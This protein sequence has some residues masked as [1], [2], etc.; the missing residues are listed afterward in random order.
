[1]AAGWGEIA[2]EGYSVEGHEALVFD[3][4]DHD[5]L[6]VEPYGDH[7][8][9]AW[10]TSLSLEGLVGRVKGPLRDQERLS[11]EAGGSWTLTGADR[12]ETCSGPLDEFF[13][14]LIKYE[15]ELDFWRF[16]LHDRAV[17]WERE[18][19]ST[20][21]SYGLMGFIG[22]VFSEED[23]SPLIGAT[24]TQVISEHLEDLVHQGA[25]LVSASQERWPATE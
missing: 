2:R 25:E 1:M 11:G 19:S 18:S 13:D 21:P 5:R 6:F 4:G 9:L 7:F 20:V 24:A 8:S 10:T 22:V 23:L 3:A 12:D 17:T 15:D 16:D 14:S